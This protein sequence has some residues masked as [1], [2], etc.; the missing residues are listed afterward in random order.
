MATPAKQ[1]KMAATPRMRQTT[2]KTV[3]WASWGTGMGEGFQLLK[4]S[5]SGWDELVVMH[6]TRSTYVASTAFKSPVSAR[7]FVNLSPTFPVVKASETL[8]I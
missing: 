3:F 7:T 4:S 2:R 1:M 6:V 8:F 5:E